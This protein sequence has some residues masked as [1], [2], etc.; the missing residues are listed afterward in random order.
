MVPRIWNWAGAATEAVAGATAGAGT[1]PEL[2]IG[3]R[4]GSRGLVMLSDIC[5]SIFSKNRPVFRS[6]IYFFNGF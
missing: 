6:K 5:F 1:G 4:T 3:A 2:G